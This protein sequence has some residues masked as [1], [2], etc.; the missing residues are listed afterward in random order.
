MTSTLCPP[1]HHSVR[2]PD[3]DHMSGPC[4]VSRCDRLGLP[5]LCG[6]AAW[7]TTRVGPPGATGSLC[8]SN[9]VCTREQ[10]ETAVR[11]TVTMVLSQAISEG[12]NQSA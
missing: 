7:S 10:R 1:A 12:E 8:Q 4:A 5:Q 6:L 9:A 3:T 11:Q 2:Q